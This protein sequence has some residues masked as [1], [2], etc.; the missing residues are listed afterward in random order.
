MDANNQQE[1]ADEGKVK[2]GMNPDGRPTSLEV[3]ELYH[4]VTP[5]NMNEEP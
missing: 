3:T 4:S 2:K 1:D 5:Q